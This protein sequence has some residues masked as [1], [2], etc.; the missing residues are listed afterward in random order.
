M[1]RQRLVPK[2]EKFSTDDRATAEKIAYQKWQQIQKEKPSLAA[3]ILNRRRAQGLATKDRALAEKIAARLWRQMQRDDPELAAK[4]LQDNRS[5]AQDHWYGK[6]VVEGQHRHIGSYTSKAEARAAYTREFEEAFGYPP[7][8]NVQCLPKIDKVWPSWQEETAR[9]ERMAERPRMPVVCQSD[10]TESLAPLIQRMQK[11]GWLVGHV[12]VVF[13]EDSPLASADI[14]IQSR[15]VTWYEQAV[16][17]DRHPVIYGCARLD[18]DTRRIRITVY[19]PGFQT[20]QVLAEE[21]YHIGL[22]ILFHESPRLFAAIRR[23]H[24]SQL[25]E[26]CDATFSLADRFASMMALEETG[27]RTSLPATV[28]TSARRLLAPTIDV[29]AS[30]MHKLIAHWSEALPA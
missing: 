27:V 8:Y 11:V 21:I 22:K 6:L 12:R 9:L 24:R 29:P 25:A 16:S 30:V 3:R 5:K 1:G 26:G 7:G 17:Q 14:A 2:G 28:V 23:W 4:I 20:R 18:P 10:D 19:R 15:G 13:D